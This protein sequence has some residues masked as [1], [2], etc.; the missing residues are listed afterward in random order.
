MLGDTVKT[1]EKHYAPFVPALRERV[2]RIMESGS[3][4]ERSKARTTLNGENRSVQ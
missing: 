2:P 3:G 1:V 4:I